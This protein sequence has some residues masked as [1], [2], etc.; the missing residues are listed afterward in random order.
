VGRATDFTD[1]TYRKQEVNRES[2]RAPRFL[3]L[4]FW[5]RTVRS[6]GGG[7]RATEGRAPR[8]RPASR[9]RCFTP[10]GLL[11]AWRLNHP[12]HHLH[13]SVSQA[14][15]SLPSRWNRGQGKRPLA[16]RPA[17]AGRRAAAATGRTDAV[18]RVGTDRCFPQ[19]RPALAVE[20]QARCLALWLA[21]GSAQTGRRRSNTYRELPSPGFMRT[22]LGVAHI[23]RGSFTDRAARNRRHV[24]GWNSNAEPSVSRHIAQA[25]AVRSQL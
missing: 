2:P 16:T 22:C 17:R 1:C 15:L 18:R 8:Q 12:V 5:G 25:L 6:T 14:Q 20:G 11:S 24:I 19:S 4:S 7:L 3:F 10:H 21:V 9:G 23:R 13:R